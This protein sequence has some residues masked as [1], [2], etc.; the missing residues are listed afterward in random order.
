MR[1]NKNIL[2]VAMVLL[3]AACKKEEPIDFL[4]DKT[5]GYVA[6]LRTGLSNRS[7]Q[8]NDTVVLTATTW[9]R[10]DDIQKVEFKQTLFEEFGLEFE[11]ITTKFTTNDPDDTRL[12][13]TDTIRS[14]ETWFTTDTVTGGLNRFYNTEANAYV[15]FA[16]FNDF[17][18]EGA[19]FP[20]EGDG[21]LDRLS[22]PDFRQLVSQLALVITPTE[23]LAFFPTAPD[24]HF[25]FS[26]AVKTGLT[27]TGRN[28][29]RTNLTKDLLKTT[30]YKS[31]RKR[32]SLSAILYAVV[33][34]GTG[35]VT[36]LS[37][38]IK[39]NYQ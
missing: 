17:D 19:N 12:V 23:Y 22:N 13:I 28:N 36:E 10:D 6:E 24:D 8:V 27:E 3:L 32:G 5:G 4:A 11:L 34:T 2:F 25:T 29:L 39:A 37:N 9:H 21:L 18:L 31:I 7:P 38:T 16:S 35:A 33:T 15:V 20:L 26:G 14:K 30:G 1:N